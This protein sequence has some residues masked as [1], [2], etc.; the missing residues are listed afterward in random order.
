MDKITE[1][2]QLYEQCRRDGIPVDG[3]VAAIAIQSVGDYASIRGDYYNS[4]F[5]AFSGYLSGNVG[6][7]TGQN[8]AKTATA[9]AFL[10]AFETGWTANQGEGA[11]YDPDPEDSDWLA[12]RQ[13]QEFAF[14]AG[15]FA[16]MEAM[17][18]DTEEPITDDE[19]TQFATDRANGYCATLDA[20]Y[21]EGKLR[22]RKNVMLEFTGKNGSPDYACQKNNGT[23]VRLMGQWHRAKWWI[24]HGLVPYMGNPNYTCG[25]WECEH[26][27]QDK[28]GNRWTGVQE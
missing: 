14:L 8:E 16:T 4:L 7:S 11:T 17:R 24:G 15:L 21:A 6:S 25:G 26:F 1:L 20:V 18:K 2:R 12:N 23:C 19:I 5:E 28:S 9:T 22:S 27:L 13:E 10:D 3:H